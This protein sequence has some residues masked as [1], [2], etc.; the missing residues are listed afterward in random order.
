[1]PEAADPLDL[2]MKLG[3]SLALGGII[4]IQR[5]RSGSDIGGIRTFP[6]CAAIGT[7]LAMASP[8]GSRAWV[9]LGGLLALTALL[10]SS[11]WLRPVDK[12]DPGITTEVAALLTLLIGA[13]VYSGPTIV[14]VAMGIVLLGILEFKPGLHAFAQ[15][16]QERDI[17][18]ILQ[19]GLVTFIILPILPNE[20]FGPFETLNP[21]KTW[22]MV[23]LVAGMGLAGYVGIKLVGVKYGMLLS[24]FLGGLVSS[25]ATTMTFARRS[26]E[27]EELSTIGTVVVM[28]ACTM[29][30]F[31]VT[32]EAAVVHRGMVPTLASRF[33]VMLI[34]ALVVTYWLFRKAG[35][36]RSDAPPE[37][38]N[39][40]DLKTAVTF[41]ILYAGIL[42]VLALCKQYLGNAGLYVAAT[43]SGLTDMDAITLSTAGLAGRGD[44]S[45]ATATNL[46]VVATI[47]NTIFKGSAAS[48]LASPAMKRQLWLGFGSIVVSGIV[49]LLWF[50]RQDLFAMLGLG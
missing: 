49:A 25:T 21:Q 19:F 31:R 27:D 10:I 17:N 3:T 41:G 32:I 38:K 35:S 20:P 46:I 15:K 29:L 24:G 23:V 48:V 47:S 34:P 50:N 5:Q 4:G 44:I 12:R 2:M 30:F 16:I 45:D 14:A 11:N 26:R 39:P 6:I 22:Y 1:M 13:V 33:A 36:A 7:F 40:C 9:I 42:L 8:A 37:V 18:A 28:L 43:V